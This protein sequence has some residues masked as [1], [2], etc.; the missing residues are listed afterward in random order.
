[1]RDIHWFNHIFGPF[2]RI[3]HSSYYLLD[4][5]GTKVHICIILVETRLLYVLWT[6]WPHSVALKI[7][8]WMSFNDSTI[9]LSHFIV[10]CIRATIYLITLER[11]SIF[12]SDLLKPANY[13]YCGL[14]D[15]I[16]LHLRLK[17][18]CHSLTKP[19]LLAISWHCA[20]QPQF[21]W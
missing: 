21:S 20:F 7:E 9:F 3:L 4:N 16:Q 15:I 5:F 2:H 12:V 6:S 8:N 19:D 10:F 18:E 17:M 11:S 1:M 14:V 13:M